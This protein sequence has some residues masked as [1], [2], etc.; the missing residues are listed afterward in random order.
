M[1]DCK[2]DVTI[3]ND[4]DS[5]HIILLTTDITIVTIYWL[6]PYKKIDRTD[7]SIRGGVLVLASS[8]NNNHHFLGISLLAYFYTDYIK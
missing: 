8:P 2:N 7:Q 6:A 1:C 4:E 3:D 5:S